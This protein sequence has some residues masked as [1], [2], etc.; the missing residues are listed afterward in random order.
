MIYLIGIV[1]TLGF[2]KIL[3]NEKI[4]KEKINNSSLIFL[5][6]LCMIPMLIISSLRRYDVGTDLLNVYIGGFERVNSGIN[7]DN[8]EIGFKTLL[9]VLG[10]ISQSPQFLVFVTS[11]LFIFFTWKA[12]YDES[13]N[14]VFSFSILFASRYYFISLNVIRQYIGMAIVLYAIQFI[15]KHQYIQFIL[16]ILLAASFHRSLILCLVLLVFDYFKLNKKSRLI[17]FSIVMLIIVLLQNTA[18]ISNIIS[19]IANSFDKYSMYL[20]PTAVSGAYFASF[21]FQLIQ[22]MFNVI[23]LIIMLG[24]YKKLKDNT[25]YNLFLYFQLL[26]LMICFLMG[27]VPLMERIYWIFGFSQIIAIPQSISAYSNR[28]IKIATTVIILSL[29]TAFCVYD[30][31][32]LYDHQVAPYYSIF[33]NNV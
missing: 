4:Q 17:G 6:I 19:N 23:I 13:V 14:I 29:M 24:A 20:G 30:I 27:S 21:R 10:K 3:S 11:F 33:S 12:I 8:F 26:A 32:I 31:F 16:L 7:T 25:Y 9:Q 5:E 22:I 15:T 28:S 18:V 1:L 2:A